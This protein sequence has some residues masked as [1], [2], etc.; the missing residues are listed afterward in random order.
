MIKEMKVVKGYKESPEFYS[1]APAIITA[2]E[3]VTGW[4]VFRYYGITGV[5]RVQQRKLE[6]EEWTRARLCDASQTSDP[7]LRHQVSPS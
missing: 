6:E 4:L 1:H 2:I 7:D 5:P 3:A